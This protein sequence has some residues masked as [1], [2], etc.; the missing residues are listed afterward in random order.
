MISADNSRQRLL[1][2]PVAVCPI[3]YHIAS[4]LE[5]MVF[6]SRRQTNDTNRPGTINITITGADP[7]TSGFGQGGA[8]H[9]LIPFNFCE[10]N[11]FPTSGLV[12]RPFRL[13]SSPRQQQQ[14]LNKSHYRIEEVR[15][16]LHAKVSPLGEMPGSDRGGPISQDKGCKNCNKKQ[17]ARK[18]NLAGYCDG[19][20]LV[21]APWVSITTSTW[22]GR[23]P[24]FNG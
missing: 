9:L 5:W 15:S 22:L 6:P 21:V 23:R 20:C 12:V 17:Q 16:T 8:N 14:Q 19:C 24:E 2:W 1:A 7:S 3:S 10:M 4:Q 18:G 11:S 13:A